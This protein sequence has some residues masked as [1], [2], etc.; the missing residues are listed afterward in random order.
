MA[1]RGN[2]LS[3]NPNMC[4]SC[5][6]LADGLEDIEPRTAALIQTPSPEPM[7]EPP[8]RRASELLKDQPVVLGPARA[9]LDNSQ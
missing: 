7:P 8:I 5:S 6:S 3:R 1:K 9:S 4:A 2:A